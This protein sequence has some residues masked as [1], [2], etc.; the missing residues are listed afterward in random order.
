MLTWI[1][2]TKFRIGGGPDWNWSQ[3]LVPAKWRHNDKD[4][5]HVSFRVFVANQ[6]W[7]LSTWCWCR[8]PRI[9]LRPNPRIPCDE[10]SKKR[11]CF[12]SSN[13]CPFEAIKGISVV[14][15]RMYRWGGQIRKNRTFTSQHYVLG[16]K[17]QTKKCFSRRPRDMTIS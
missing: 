12:L 7:S 9:Q 16:I 10:E 2:L 17:N 8:K 14:F 13:G 11:L 4:L 3:H 15:P 6:M 5:N 1:C